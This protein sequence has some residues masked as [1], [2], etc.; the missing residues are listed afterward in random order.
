[1]KRIKVCVAFLLFIT[2]LASG[3]VSKGDYDKAQSDLTTAQQLLTSANSDRDASKTQ[4]SKVESDLTTAQQ[5]LSKAQSDLITAQQSLS[6]I[7]AD[8]DNLKNQL[9][10]AQSDLIAAQQSL[11][12][13]NG[14]LKTAQPYIDIAKGYLNMALAGFSESTPDAIVA[15]SQIT[16]GLAVSNDSALKEAWATFMKSPTNNATN[17]SF[18]K[19]LIQRLSETKPKTN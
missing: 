18:V 12:T 6:T 8:R 9:S 16:M 13:L 5:S 1:M 2:L 14:S 15:I 10:K 11:A 3:C 4:L 7:T 19:L 17:I